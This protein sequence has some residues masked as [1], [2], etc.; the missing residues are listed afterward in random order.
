VFCAALVACNA[1]GPSLNDVS[2]YAKRCHDLLYADASASA[3]FSHADEHSPQEL[4]NTADRL[5]NDAGS[6]ALGMGAPD[7]FSES[8]EAWENYA[9]ELSDS[10]R[11]IAN[12]LSDP[13]IQNSHD[14]LEAI[15]GSSGAAA[16]AMAAFKHD[17]ANAPFTKQEKRRILNRLI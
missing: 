7:G 9:Q 11:K 15:H 2:R 8:G 13:T 3:Y 17:L 10:Y 6:M 12:A 4:Y 16:K 5:S 14:M 1:S